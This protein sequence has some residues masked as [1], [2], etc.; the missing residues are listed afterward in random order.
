[1]GI[2]EPALPVT[3]PMAEKQD[4]LPYAVKAAIVIVGIF[5]TFSYFAILQEDVYKKKYNG[6]KFTYT[7]FVLLIERSMNSLVAYIGM[8]L[9]AKSKYKVPIQ[10]ISISGTTQMIAMGASNEALRYVSYPT[11]VLGK[12]C[13]MVPVFIAGILLAGKAAEYALADYLQVGIVT[14]GVCVFNFGG[15][16]KAGAD[17]SSYGLALIG[18][19]LMC[20][21]ATGGLQ[22]KVKAITKKINHDDDAKISMFE[23]MFYTNASG[24]VVALIL[25]IGSGQLTAGASMLAGSGALTMAV[26]MFAMLSALG[27]CF[28]FYTINEFG[29]LWL[30]TLTTTRKIFST[31]YSVFRDPA[32]SLASMQWVGVALVFGGIIMSE[33]RKALKPKGKT[34]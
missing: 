3:V 16:A 6:E 25:A 24:A 10:E 31:V 4:G 17:D 27:Q 33:A 18:L 26:M 19:S 14:L 12:S 9:S 21:G 20:D 15:K 28:V 32:N 29:P 2:A 8:Q 30:T 5:G 11:Q 22:D 34:K 13:K 7:L 23:S 1:M